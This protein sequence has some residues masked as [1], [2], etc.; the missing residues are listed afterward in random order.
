MKEIFQSLWA[1]HKTSSDYIK[2]IDQNVLCYDEEVNRSVT[3]KSDDESS[4]VH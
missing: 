3:V 2:Y 4:S 1:F